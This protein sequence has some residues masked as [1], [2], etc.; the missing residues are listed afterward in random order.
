MVEYRPTHTLDYQ[1]NLHMEQVPCP[2]FIP[3]CLETIQQLD[4][5]PRELTNFLV[6]NLGS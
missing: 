3:M 5:L 6:C 4:L 1:Q 2:L